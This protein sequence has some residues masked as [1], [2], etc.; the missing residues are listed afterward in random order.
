MT[1][2]AKQK[3]FIGLQHIV[4]QHFI[5]RVVGKLAASETHWIKD[6][7]IRQFAKKFDIDMSEAEQESL[8]AYPSFNAFFTRALK[9]GARPIDEDKN[10]IV[11][12]ADGAVSECGV[13][14]HGRL[15]QAK[16]HDFSLHTLLGAQHD[17]T[18]T[19]LNGH[20]ATIYLSPRDYHRVHM[21]F[22]GT[23]RK[24]IYVPGDLY[25]VNQT[26]ANGVDGLFAKNERLVCIFDTD[27][28]PMA[29]VLVGAMI[30]AGIETV[31]S[32]QVCPLANEKNVL[33][34]DSNG[35]SIPVKL[36][37]GEE[38][39]RFKLGSTAIIV[40]PENTIAWD[41]FLEAGE[42]VRMGQRIGQRA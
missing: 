4:P 39:G 31:W 12:P 35:Q 21:P 30:V 1:L 7:F 28:G 13:I 32:G 42:P 11:S 38:M 37:K 25:S 20:F 14:K 16:G 34:F 19:F 26:T 22:G 29:L 5:S 18:E 8:G 33:E 40:T 17:L 10:S 27:L 36:G 2:N 15:I 41:E 6:T 9:D 23:L 24:T 3:L